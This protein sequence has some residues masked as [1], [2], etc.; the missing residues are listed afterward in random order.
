MALSHKNERELRAN[1]KERSGIIG[2][3]FVYGYMIDQ[4]HAHEK[5][6]YSRDPNDPY[7][8]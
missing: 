1:M 8:G 6:S 5:L 3:K 2:Y 7:A 4:S